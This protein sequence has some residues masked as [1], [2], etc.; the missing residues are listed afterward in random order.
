MQSLVLSDFFLGHGP[1]NG[2]II[3][4]S[5]QILFYKRKNFVIDIVLDFIFFIMVSHNQ[6][7]K[8]VLR[9]DLTVYSV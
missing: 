1:Q 9:D 5:G 3:P 4:L 2:C 7:V 6:S 8:V